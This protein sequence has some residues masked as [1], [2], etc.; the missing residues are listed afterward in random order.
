MCS[1]GIVRIIERLLWVRGVVIV[2]VVGGIAEVAGGTRISV[3]PVVSIQSR[4][5]MSCLLEP[6][7][8]RRERG[9][10]DSSA[11]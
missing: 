5:S 6:Q 10:V 2:W 8:K 9:P 11:S 7:L 4:S 3:L 1:Y